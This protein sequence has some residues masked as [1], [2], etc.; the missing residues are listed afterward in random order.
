MKYRAGS[1]LAATWGTLLF[2]WASPQPN[3]IPDWENP[4]VFAKNQVPAHSLS[5]PAAD[6]DAARTADFRESPYYLSLNGPWQF[7]WA[8]NP[9]AAP[10]EFFRSGFD[11][12]A[13]G[14]IEVPSNWQVLGYGNPMFRNVAHPF[15]SDPPRVPRDYNP[16]GSYRRGFSLPDHWAGRRIFLHFEGVHSASTIWLN[17][18]EV[19]YNQGGMEP[20][21]YEITPYLEEGANL[22]A[23]QVL[24][25]S[26]GSYLECQDMWRLSGIY[27]DV[28]LYATPDVHIFD[29]YLRTDLE[30][31]YQSAQLRADLEI[32]NFGGRTWRDLEVS[33]QLFTPEGEPVSGFPVAAGPV[34][35]E[36]GGSQ[37]LAFSADVGDPR[38]WSAEDPNLYTVVLT[39]R[40]PADPDPLEA[41]S[42]R[43]GFRQVEV[44]EQAILINGRAV[45]FNGVNRHEHE[46][47]RGRAVSRESMV[48]D[49][50]LMK[51]F[52]INLVRTS[53]YPPAREFLRLA[54][55][56]GIY[57]VDEVNDEAHMT[58]QL[59]DDPAWRDAFLDRAERMVLRD[60]NHPSIIFWSAG[61]ESGTG[62]NLAA[63]IQRG[64]QLDPSRPAWM[65]GATSLTP[66]QPF[67]EIVGPRYPTLE[68]LEAIARVPAEDD[69]RPSF[70]DEYAA[71]T[72]NSL[73]HL[74]EYWDLI[75]RYRRLTGGA[76]WDWVSPG[77]ASTFRIAGDSTSRHGNQGY[78]FGPARLVEGKFGRAIALSGH[79]EW[80]EMYRDP[81]LDFL[82]GELTL[83]LWVRPG[84]W[85]GTN[86]LLTKGSDYGLDQPAKGRLRFYVM[87]RQL[88]AAIGATPDDWEGNW[89]QVSGIFDGTRLLLVVDGAVIGEAPFE[90]AV[91]SL[92][93]PVAI[94]KN[95]HTEG[96]DHDGPISNAAFDSVRVFHS[97]LAIR[98]LPSPRGED[99]VLWLDFESL[100]PK[101][102]FTSLGIGARS[103][104]LIWA[105]RTVQPELWQLK[106]VGQPVRV[107]AVDA[108]AGRFEIHNRYHFTNLDQLEANWELASEL[109]P[110]AQGTLALDLAA[111]DVT[112]IQ[113]ELPKT[114]RE[115]GTE[116]WILFRFLLAEPK[117]WAPRGHEVAWAQFFLPS[118][119]LSAEPSAFSERP[120]G[121]SGGP[122]SRE[123]QGHPLRVVET[124]TDWVITGHN[125][126]WVLSRAT[127]D[128]TSW[129]FQGTEL[130]AGTPRVNLWRAPTANEL[131]EWRNPPIAWQW[132]EIGLDRL[133]AH[134]Q[135]TR[136]EHQP[137]RP[138][139]VVSERRLL[140]GGS[141]VTFEV[142][143]E[144]TFHPSGD[145]ALQHEVTSRGEFPEWLPGVPSWLPRVGLQ[146]EMPGNFQH[147][148]WFGRGPFE[149][150]P[151]RKTGARVGIFQEQAAEGYIPYLIPQDHGN[152]TDV[153]WI[154]LTNTDGTG[155][156]IKGTDLSFSVQRF[157]Q[158]N[159]FRALYPFQLTE[160]N[161][162]VVNL[163]Y[164]VTGLGD[165]PNPTLPAYRIMPE[166]YR[167]TTCLS[168]FRSSEISAAKKGMDATV[169][170]GIP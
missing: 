161:A 121:L 90:G 3:A 125:S 40:S 117:L 142:R 86:S 153:R 100:G 158:D 160:R 6:P 39:L 135:I 36:V 136:L 104:G 83:S 95:V 43:I 71:A 25:Y 64:H 115:S 138:I 45:K 73:G 38:L 51:Q 165:T 80:I 131:D 15:R 157:E 116:H 63:L 162:L 77:L 169:C 92:R 94:G 87:G 59:S 99:S 151:D 166:T 27:R 132:Y 128:L 120:P 19:G 42:S 91:R 4:R 37:V 22:L 152:R 47:T 156:W 55:Q 75:R 97:A 72:G 101:E 81:S 155:L 103:Y 2:G 146:F 5:I 60:R 26:D 76:V 168:P 154:A 48:R 164:R 112:R 141:P 126:I 129:R 1:V 53:H 85:N 11:A 150:Y 170:T 107:E 13:W 163:D 23:V 144:L 111:G 67:E 124:E 31:S 102:P 149:T 9:A 134:D 68:A 44:L 24:A 139:R 34:N 108:E 147:L 33:L 57:V 137:G 127:G 106:K 35:L 20:A 61:N 28:Y 41:V 122:T 12:S 10:A 66:D 167:W 69:P 89:H 133:E 96:Q 98:D 130:L 32:R 140:A 21:E 18:R 118:R 109:G 93:W 52:N 58:P 46:L 8:E 17:G 50:E 148:Q 143:T 114:S 14:D 123:D 159:L 110:L 56:Y 79:D 30:P 16:V 119:Q 145:L 113:L 84:P 74:D 7:R 105:D 54:D 49:L 78:V 29:F 70:M 65:Y 82:G 88:A 62:A